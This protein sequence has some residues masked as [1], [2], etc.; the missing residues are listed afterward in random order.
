[1]FKYVPPRRPPGDLPGTEISNE[2]RDRL[3][4]SHR[5]A[6]RHR[7]ARTRLCC[8]RADVAGARRH[9]NRKAAA[10]RLE[11]DERRSAFLLTAN[12][13][14]DKHGAAAVEVD[15]FVAPDRPVERDAMADAEFLSAFLVRCSQLAVADDRESEICLCH[16]VEQDVEPLVPVEAVEL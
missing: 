15:Q 16:R 13:R 8:L 12:R 9:Y 5:V 1:I 14:K 10:H 3:T 6:V 4:E 7:D 2:T 11:D